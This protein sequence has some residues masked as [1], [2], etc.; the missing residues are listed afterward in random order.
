MQVA[1]LETTVSGFFDGVAGLQ[2]VLASI[3]AVLAGV[4]SRLMHAWCLLLRLCAAFYATASCQPE[5]A[6][7][8][9]WSL[10]WKGS[11]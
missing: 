3:S 6:L 4:R 8:T 2:T 11:N 5:K 10:Q 9:C 7:M 1:T